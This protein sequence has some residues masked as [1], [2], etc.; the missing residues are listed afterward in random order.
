MSLA[1][2]AKSVLVLGCGN[3]LLGDDGFGPAVIEY[4]EAHRRIPEHVSCVDAGTSVREI[5]FDLLL[6]EE[7]PRQIIVVDAVDVAGRDPG[8]IFA[9]AVDQISPAKIAD[10]SLHQFPTV[11]LLRD[12]RD[13]TAVDVRILAVQITGIPDEVRPGLSPPVA[14]AIPRMGELILKTVDG[15]SHD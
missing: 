10:Y 4:L 2:P 7:K 1:H 14:A 3:P 11:N 15:G 9:V 12:L 5:L 13:H 8:E 6:S